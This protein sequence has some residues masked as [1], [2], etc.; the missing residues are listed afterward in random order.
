MR[1]V[2]SNIY[3][4]K[5]LNDKMHGYGRLLIASGIIF[6][7]NLNQ[8]ICESI[9]KLLYMSGDIYFGQHRGFVKD[10]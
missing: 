1:F 8:N 3:Q 6:E 4:G 2:N 7:G 9:G 5:F 10:G